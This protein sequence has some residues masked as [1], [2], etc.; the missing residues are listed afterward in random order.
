MLESPYELELKHKSA[1]WK[2]NIFKRS[3]SLLQ[4][5]GVKRHLRLE[6]QLLRMFVLWSRT[7]FSHCVIPAVLFLP[8]DFYVLRHCRHLHYITEPQ[9]HECCIIFST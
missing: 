7:V 5:V 4:K 9:I 8:G 3:S 2:L 6:F 1:M